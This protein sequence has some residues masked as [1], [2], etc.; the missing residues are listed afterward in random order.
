MEKEEKRKLP[1]SIILEEEFRKRRAVWMSVLGKAQRAYDDL[2]NDSDVGE[3]LPDFE[4]L[5][6][7]WIKDFISEKVDAVMHSPNTYKSRVET[8]N[9]WR[10]LE[11]DLLEKIG[12]I[13]R[14][15]QIDSEAKI[16]IRGCHITI[17]NMDD[18]LKD[19][20]VFVV[21]EDFKEF[22]SMVVSCSD[23]LKKFNEYKKKW[24][25]KEPIIVNC[26]VLG[27]ANKPEDFVRFCI[28]WQKKQE[29]EKIHNTPSE[30]YFLNQKSRNELLRKENERRIN[31]KR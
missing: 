15:K 30:L 25:M 5:N 10:N 8:A 21:P 27:L 18:L 19:K 1:D 20:T 6:S 29:W 24:G 3:L 17:S 28:D 7:K 23:E 11:A 4:N 16:E 2:L 13:E 9:E 26:A 12:M 14:L 22:Y 31:A